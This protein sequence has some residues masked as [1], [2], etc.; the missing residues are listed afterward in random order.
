[1]PEGSSPSAPLLAAALE[2]GLDFLR[3]SQR[4]SGEFTTYSADRPDLAGASPFPK[5][6][7]ATTFVV[8]ALSCLP[9][10][11]GV[12]EMQRR[13]GDFL[14]GEQDPSGAWNYHGRGEWP[15]PPDLDDTCCAVA[16]LLKL[17]RHPDLSF[18]S[19]LWENES[20][21]SGPY[22]TWI[23]LNDRPGDPRAR[24]IDALVNAN[25]LFCCGLLELPLPGTAAYLRR[26]IEAGAYLSHSVYC[27][28]PHLLIYTLSRAYAEGR[29]GAL[30]PVAPALRD[31]MLTRLA[32]PRSETSAFHLACLTA[33]LINLNAAANV[34]E[35][36]LTALLA[37]QQADGCWPAWAAWRA[38]YPS[39]HGSPALTTALALEGLAKYQNLRR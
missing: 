17:G 26:I 25:V 8:Q 36:Y 30:A 20:A 22:F 34:V 4:P 9:P 12:D 23:G 32:P 24:E 7:Y 15:I 37:R 27:V 31:E 33:S 18:Y 1:M 2:Q 39:Y 28:S 13:A 29:A 38:Y 35:P 10:G 5:A 21:P 11:P 19:L 3:R 14:A 6:V 16:A